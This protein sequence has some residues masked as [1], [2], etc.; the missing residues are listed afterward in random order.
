MSRILFTGGGG[1]IPVCIAGA[2]PACLVKVLGQV[3]VSQHAL[4]VVSQH[5]LHGG[6]QAHTLG[7]AEGSGQGGLQA[8]SWGRGGCVSQYALRQTLLWTATA[9]G[10]M[11]PTGMHSCFTGFFLSTGGWGAG[12]GV[13]LPS[14]HHKSHEQW[15]CIQGEIGSASRGKGSTSRGVCIQR[16]SA[17]GGWVDY[18]P[19]RNWE[20]GRYASHWN[21][22]SFQRL[23]SLFQ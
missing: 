16:G 18:P 20:S 11:H 8:H 15:V 17:S 1:A 14:M 13:W 19:P 21:A 22:S 12:R 6:L 23:F 5:A 7:G 3:L 4:Q 9:T 10:G 2:I